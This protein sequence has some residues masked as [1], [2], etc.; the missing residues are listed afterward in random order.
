M[1]GPQ[2]VVLITGTSSGFGRLIAETLARKNFQVFAT[3][4]DLN[5]RNAAAAREIADLAK[6][7]SLS[8]QPLE[9]DV[10]EDTSVERAV[11]KVAMKCGRIDVLVNNA[12]YGIMDLAESVTMAQAQRQFDTNFFGVLRMNRAVLP[13]MRRQGSGLLL[14]VSSGA[15]RLAIP[16]M[17][18]YCASKFA[19]EALA[20]TYRYELAGL[21]IDSVIIEPGAYATPI[22]QKLERGEDPGR[23]AGYGE[24]AQVPEGLQA[25]IASSRSNPQEIADAVLQIIET[26]AGQ[27]QLRYRLGPGG[28]GV[29]RINALTDEVQAQMLEAFGIVKETKFRS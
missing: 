4:R 10:T 6:R 22:M 26:P 16:G 11:S 9:L 27:R 3:M 18:L 20:E 19:M 1:P 2:Q 14:H 12:G 17:G 21:G 24:M 8:L 25:K 23:K 7:E 13:V 15:G 29:E 5:G 28:P